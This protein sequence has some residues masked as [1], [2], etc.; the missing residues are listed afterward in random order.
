MW[1]GPEA[2]MDH[3]GLSFLLI[4]TVSSWVPHGGRKAAA[5]VALSASQSKPRQKRETER[6]AS[7]KLFPVASVQGPGFAD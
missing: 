5:S 7:T 4:A 6:V 1:L 3:Q 2:L